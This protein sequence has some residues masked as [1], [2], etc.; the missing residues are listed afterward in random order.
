MSNRPY[1]DPF[2]VLGLT[3]TASREEVKSAFRRLAL[4]CHPDV[5]PSPQ[6]AA[7]FTEVKRA[8]DFILKGQNPTA[9][10]GYRPAAASWHAYADVA[11][12]AQDSFRLLRSRNAALWFCAV[13]LAAGFGIFYG[14]VVSHEWLDGYRW[15]T[16]EAAQSRLKHPTPRRQQLAALML[17]QQAEH[18]AAEA[19][20][21]QQQR[22]AE[23]PAD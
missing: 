23:G 13:S 18:S 21:S 14:A 19:A 2:G 11:P 7:R 12:E 10:A 6:A 1:T 9:S 15:L 4:K 3:P 22:Q 16:P 5:D 17:Q 8:A 20:S